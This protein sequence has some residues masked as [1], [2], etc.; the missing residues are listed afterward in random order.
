MNRLI[1]QLDELFSSEEYEFIYDYEDEKE[2]RIF[3][4][5]VLIRW[6]DTEP[7]VFD[8]SHTFSFPIGGELELVLNNMNNQKELLIF[9]QYFYTITTIVPTIELEPSMGCPVDDVNVYFKGIKVSLFK[10]AIAR[11]VN[12]KELTESEKDHY[13]NASQKNFQDEY[14]LYTK[15]R[16]EISGKY[17]KNTEYLVSMGFR[18]PNE[19]VRVQL[20]IAEENNLFISNE[21]GVIIGSLDDRAED[22]SIFT[23]MGPFE[24]VSCL[25][26]GIKYTFVKCEDEILCFSS[27]AVEFFKNWLDYNEIYDEIKYYT[28]KDQ[29]LYLSTRYSWA[30]LIR[31]Q[32]H[33]KRMHEEHSYLTKLIA[34]FEPFIPQELKVDFSWGNISSSD[35][36]KVC[37]ELLEIMGYKSVRNRGNSNTSDGGVDIEAI[38]YLTLI[39]GEIEERKW[40]FQCKYGKSTISRKD[41]QEIPLLLDEF[42]ADCYGLFCTGELPPQTIDRLKGMQSSGKKIVYWSNHDLKIILS[43]FPDLLKKYGLRRI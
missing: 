38:E 35:F 42:K 25:Y 43:K 41:V 4:L 40:I 13:F 10:R 6:S 11:F 20:N 21:N 7:D 26:S 30:L 14:D 39:T 17:K 27:R 33:E 29:Y 5:D 1:N 34:D 31:V 12:Y 22:T 9:A 16:E 15:Y 23:R 32:D 28:N 36:E 2:I 8:L 19:F 18:K 37:K 3:K 24:K